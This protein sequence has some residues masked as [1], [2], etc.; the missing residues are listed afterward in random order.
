MRTNTIRTAAQGEGF[1]LIEL[2][3]VIAVIAI[4]AGLLLPALARAKEQGRRA[5]CLS[6][7]KQWAIAQTMYLGDSEDALPATKIPNGTPG[8]PGDYSEDTPRWLDL[9][10]VE[11]QDRVTG[12][13]YG[14]EAWFNVL[15]PYIDSKPL[16]EYALS[17]TGPFDYKEQKS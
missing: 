15:P 13:S 5:A 8:T 14:R 4:L 6:N 16:W 17:S 9:T 11:H 12:A 2:L 7:L 1:T 10:D 3:V